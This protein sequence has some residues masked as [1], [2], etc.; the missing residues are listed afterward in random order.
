VPCRS[1]PSVRL[2][3]RGFAGHH[4]PLQKLKLEQATAFG[5]CLTHLAAANWISAGEKLGELAKIETGIK[6]AILRI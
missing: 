2:T 5:T 1:V 6:E 3:M 4:E